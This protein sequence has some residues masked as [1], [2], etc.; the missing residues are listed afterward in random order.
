M[1][2]G[3][4]GF[5]LFTGVWAVASPQSWFD[6][7]PGV[8]PDLVAAEPPFNAHL[9]TDAGA[10]FLCTGVALVVAAILGRRSGVYVALAAYLAFA[11]PHAWYHGRHDAAG[12]TGAEQAAAT[13]AVVGGIVLAL[14]LL[15]GARPRRGHEPAATPATPFADQVAAAP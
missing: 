10:A 5:Q 14:V 12:L 7:Y 8:G 9:A 1:V 11:V 3:L 4:A 15:W 2:L 6:G 13:G